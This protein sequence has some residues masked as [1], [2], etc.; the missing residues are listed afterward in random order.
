MISGAKK[1]S[2]L[3]L[4]FVCLF[5]LQF[6][7]FKW[8]SAYSPGCLYVVI[9]LADKNAYLVKSENCYYVYILNYE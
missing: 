7:L 4:F 9:F 1:K 3:L 6:A 2:I 8:H 5:F